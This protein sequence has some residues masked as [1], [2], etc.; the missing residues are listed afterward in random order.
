MGGSAWLTTRPPVAEEGANA[1]PNG[2]SAIK[3]KKPGSPR[4]SRAQPGRTTLARDP[5][6][7]ISLRT[8]QL[9]LWSL[10]DRPDESPLVQSPCQDWPWDSGILGESPKIFSG[11]VLGKQVSLSNGAALQ[12]SACK[13][14][15]MPSEVVRN[16]AEYTGWP[17]FRW[18]KRR[19][20]VRGIPLRY[21]GRGLEGVRTRDSGVAR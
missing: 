12:R 13:L 19:R 21:R 7:S 17:G 8:L 3:R 15:G 16:R 18:G 5:V 10:L 20:F 1:L 2:T 9:R 11:R 6:C 14:P 4:G